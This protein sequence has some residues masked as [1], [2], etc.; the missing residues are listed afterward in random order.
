MEQT[1]AAVG[2]KITAGAFRFRRKLAVISRRARRCV[3][4]YERLYRALN[5]RPNEDYLPRQ[6]HEI[7]D[8]YFRIFRWS[9]SIVQCR[10]VQF[11]RNLVACERLTAA[12]VGSTLA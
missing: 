6:R 10:P 7:I 8:D 9:S 5:K 3:G 11:V 4:R 2:T 12:I 1:Q